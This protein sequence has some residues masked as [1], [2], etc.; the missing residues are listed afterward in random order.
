MTIDRTV[1]CAMRRI[2]FPCVLHPARIDCESAT[3]T[4]STR[5]IR[6]ALCLPLQTQRVLLA[7]WLICAHM[8][9]L[10][11][12]SSTHHP[13]D[14]LICHLVIPGDVAERFPCSTWRSTVAHAEGGQA[15]TWTGVRTWRRLFPIPTTRSHLLVTTL[16]L[17]SSR[18]H[19]CPG[20]GKPKRF[21]LQGRTRAYAN[22]RVFLL[23]AFSRPLSRCDLCSFHP[24]LLHCFCTGD[25]ASV[26]YPRRERQCTSKRQGKVR[27]RQACNVGTWLKNVS[28]P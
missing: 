12:T 21:S 15:E 4:G 14:L 25:L 1:E 22:P 5:W 11:T 8:S 26:A 6:S 9:H 18:A 10:A 23:A 28:A 17:C 7:R 3:Y 27:E 24:P 2:R 13:P 20:D 16:A 19:R